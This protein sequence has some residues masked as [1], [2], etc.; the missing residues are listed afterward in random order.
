MD[1]PEIVVGQL[2][3]GRLLERCDL[4]PLG[5]DAAEDMADGAVLPAGVGGL[6]DDEQLLPILGVEKLLESLELIVEVLGAILGF[7][8][9]PTS[10]V[11]GRA[12]PQVDG[13]LRE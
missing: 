5:V 4:H 10:I 1:A 11:V 9:I 12:R 7:V 2:W 8:A 13:K 6:D 3:G